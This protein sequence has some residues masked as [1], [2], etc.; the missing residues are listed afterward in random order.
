MNRVILSL[1]AGVAHKFCWLSA[2]VEIGRW[3]R[4]TLLRNERSQART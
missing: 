4:G 2:I 3:L 1:G